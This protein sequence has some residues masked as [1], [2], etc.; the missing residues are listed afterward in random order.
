MQTQEQKLVKLKAKL[1]QD[2]IE[3]QKASE[4]VSK[5]YK[6][7]EKIEFEL[8]NRKYK[9][10]DPQAIDWKDL[11]MANMGQGRYDLMQRKFHDMLPE[12]GLRPECYVPETGQ[13]VLAF[14]LT[15]T[16][17]QDPQYMKKLEDTVTFMIPFLIPHEELIHFNICDPGLSQ[18][19]S[20]DI[21]LNPETNEWSVRE[22]RSRN[23]KIIFATNSTTTF[24]EYIGK[25]M[26]HSYGEDTEDDEDA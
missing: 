15:R 5:T 1:E 6:A 4:Q 21:K 11:L 16:T 24:L 10:I 3:Y 18:Y 19:T 8:A 20:Y 23:K 12:G 26:S 13:T 9:D 2:R 22:G 17:C 25:N 7:I 14:H